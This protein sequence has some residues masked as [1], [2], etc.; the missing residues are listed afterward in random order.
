MNKDLLSLP[1]DLLQS[2]LERNDIKEWENYRIYKIR[3]FN[4][5]IEYIVSST[6]PDLNPSINYDE[7][8]E[9]LPIFVEVGSEPF[10]ARIRIDQVLSIAEVY[11]SGIDGE[12]STDTDSDES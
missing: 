11:L 6:P 12:E 5:A 2:E 3:Y 10:K 7:E 9:I 8:G 1:P 4:D